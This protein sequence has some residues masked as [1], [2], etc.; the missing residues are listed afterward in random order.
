MRVLS[1][2][3]PPPPGT[4]A[5]DSSRFPPKPRDVR[6]TPS[7]GGRPA[8]CP[9]E[10]SNLRHTV[11]EDSAVSNR[12]GRLGVGSGSF[13]IPES[14]S[15]EQA[16]RMTEVS[17]HTRGTGATTRLERSRSDRKLVGVCGGLAR[18]VDI[19]PA[20]YRLASSSPRRNA[21]PT[22]GCSRRRQIGAA[23][24]TIRSRIPARYPITRPCRRRAT[25]SRCR[26]SRGAS[27]WCGLVRSDGG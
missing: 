17:T 27:A 13:W 11:D 25:A 12:E 3:T 22:L 26:A 19:H 21:L 6:R 15:A 4:R 20:V 10:D 24:G 9:R 2:S 8:Q 5:S 18:Y 14:A 1:V 16:R 7:S 23:G